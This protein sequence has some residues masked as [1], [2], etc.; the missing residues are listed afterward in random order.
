MVIEILA[1]IVG[2]FALLSIEHLFISLGFFSIWA[3]LTIY[4]YQKLH[5]PFLWISLILVGGALGST[6][7]IGTGTYLLSVAIC[8]LLLY[9]IKSFIPDD[10][11]LAK[12]LPYIFIFF[13]FY[14]LRDVFGEIS[15][16]GVFPSIQWSD[17]LSFTI[18]SIV[19]T[20]LVILIDLAY[21]QFRHNG[22]ISRKGTG[23]EIRRR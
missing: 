10:S 6:V 13:L 20:G 12:Y 21:V 1:S 16:N 14:I 2:L 3:F 8:L 11:F 7:G 22:G 4:S 19:S 18:S 23:I 15:N 5:S 9:L 17:I